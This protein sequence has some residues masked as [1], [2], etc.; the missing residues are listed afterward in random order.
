[1]SDK[2]TLQKV[3]IDKFGLVLDIFDNFIINLNKLSDE[4]HFSLE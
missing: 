3:P 1:M 4:L 2:H